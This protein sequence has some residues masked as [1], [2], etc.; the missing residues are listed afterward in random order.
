MPESE[1]PT[2]EGDGRASADDL[3]IGPTVLEPG[4]KDPADSAGSRLA[5][6]LLIPLSLVLLVLVLTFFV[7]FDR[8]H[9]DGPSMMPTLLNR[10]LVL[11]TKSYPQP[12]RGDVVFTQVQ[13]QG[14]PVELVKRVIGLPGDTIEIRDDTAIVNGVPEPQRGQ[15]V[16]PPAGDSFQPMTVP[17]GHLYV[18][19]DN[20][21][22]SEDSRY[23]GPVPISGVMGRV[24]AIYAPIT[25][26][27]LVR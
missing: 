24:V 14:Q 15:F 16:Y 25:R 22:N 20:R 13:E 4:P 1:L 6:V 19:G 21:P 18:M 3:Y 8:G 7:F 17:E 5:S 9:V 10:D 26:I 11:V 2:P 12:R 23:I 27:R